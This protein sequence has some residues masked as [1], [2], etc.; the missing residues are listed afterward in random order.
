[1]DDAAC[2]R[3]RVL[4]A[5]IQAGAYTRG[6]RHYITRSWSH[7]LPSR[8]KR[9]SLDAIAQLASNYD[10]VG[11][12]ESDP[13]SLRSGFTNQTHYLA[14]QAR[15]THWRQQINRH[16]G[17]LAA[18]ANGLLSQLPPT[19][20]TLYP[21]PGRISGRGLLI[22]QYG[23]GQEGL[24]VAVTHLSLG[25]RSRVKQLEFIAELLSQYANT[26]L[27]GDF[28]CAA[29]EP[30]MQ[31]LYRYTRLT[32]PQSSVLTFPSWGPQ[33]AIDHI[34]VSSTLTHDALQTFPA[35]HSDHLALGTTLTVPKHMLA[36]N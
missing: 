5:N 13:G 34:F 20:V 12:Q 27:M 16:V 33:R 3:L 18:S 6:Y 7:A 28:N 35:A 32:M 1:M 23:Q 26:V 11:L 14:R 31:P 29:S 10:I 36:V 19:K 2:Y 24:V 17:K 9:V 22:A 8:Q 30:E 25:Y 4:T 21:L 15:F